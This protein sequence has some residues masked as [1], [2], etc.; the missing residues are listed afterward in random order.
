M[1]G[2]L[3][4]TFDEINRLRFDVSRSNQPNSAHYPDTA[5]SLNHDDELRL[6]H[7]HAHQK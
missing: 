5:Y 3:R 6:R 7:S 1:P 4:K 2:R